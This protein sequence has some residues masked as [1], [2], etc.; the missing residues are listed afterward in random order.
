MTTRA[1]V[2]MVAALAAL[3]AGFLYLQVLTRRVRSER[4]ERGEEAARAKLNEAALQSQQGPTQSAI[5]YFPSQ[6]EGVLIAESR[7]M[8]WAQTD[9]DRIRQVLLALIEGSH[10]GQSRPLP[11]STDI[12]AVFLTSDG[13]SY[14]DFSSQALALFPSGIESETLALYSIADSLAANVPSVKRVRILV[15]GQEVDSLNGHADVSGPIVPDPARI[16]P[17]S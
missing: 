14:L 7:P 10:Q 11:P 9:T 17:A 6:D 3:L 5:L 12:R 1:K 13:T 2:L 8:A 4:G 16:K 15:Q